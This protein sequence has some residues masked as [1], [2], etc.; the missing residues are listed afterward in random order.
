MSPATIAGL[1]ILAAVYVLGWCLLRI[2]SRDWLSE[3]PE[4]GDRPETTTTEKPQL[5]CIRGG[6]R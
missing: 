3:M 5:R 6:K 4:R 1:L 2:A